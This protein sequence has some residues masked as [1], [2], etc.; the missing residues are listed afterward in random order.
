M[1]NAAAEKKARNVR[2]ITRLSPGV[3]DVKISLGTRHG[4]ITFVGKAV[5]LS[6]YVPD[7]RRSSLSQNAIDFFGQHLSSIPGVLTNNSR[8]DVMPLYKKSEV[9]ALVEDLRKR[10]R[11]RKSE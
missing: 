4:V 9:D 5:D 11:D 3:Y 10:A 7:G 8:G 2:E 1:R 6:E